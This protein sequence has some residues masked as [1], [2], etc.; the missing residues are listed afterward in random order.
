M[1]T[2]ELSCSEQTK[3]YSRRYKRRPERRFSSVMAPVREFRVAQARRFHACTLFAARARKAIISVSGYSPQDIRVNLAPGSAPGFPPISAPGFLQGSAQR[4]AAI[5]PQ[6]LHNESDVA[7]VLLCEGGCGWGC[8]GG[9][10]T[11]PHPPPMQMEGV[12]MRFGHTMHES[13]CITV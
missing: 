12:C 9:G 11:P 1:N 3:K 6:R 7:H 2:S 8:M 5:A 13:A 10:E 4:F